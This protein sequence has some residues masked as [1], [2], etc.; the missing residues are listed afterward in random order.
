[1]AIVV[2]EQIRLSEILPSDKAAL[3]EHLKEKEIYDQ[4]LLIPFP[5]TEA[6]AD[7]FLTVVTEEKERLGQ[8]FHWAIRD[9]G[10]HLI[11][12]CGLKDFAPG[13]SHRAEIGYWLAKPYWGR[14]VMTAVVRTLCAHAR[15][16][17]GLIKITAHVF[18]FNHGSA[19]VLE[20]CGFHQE[21][22]LKKH[23]RKDGRLIDVRLYALIQE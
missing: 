2:S 1:M 9:E 4:T 6:D 16:E 21:G 5:Y 23:L 22:Y 13:Q 7:K 20:K 18:A 8:S 14:G 3:V 19:R 15:S 10:N 12:G 17:L 11:G